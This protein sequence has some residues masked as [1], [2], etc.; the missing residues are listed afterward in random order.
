MALVRIVEFTDPGCP[1]A[2]SAE[3]FRRRIDWLYGDHIEWRMHMVGLSESPEDYLDKGFTP[4]KM[5]R[6]FADIAREHHMPIATH[7]RPRMAATLPAC[8][9]VVAAREHEGE[10]SARRLLRQLRVRH[11]SGG[12]L[13]DPDTIEAAARD[14]SIDPEKLRGWLTDP[15]V[16]ARLRV[17]MAAARDPL[18]AALVLEHRLAPWED[19]L[20]Y[21][22]PSYE[23]VRSSDGARSAVPGFQPFAAY[24]VVLANLLPDVARLGPPQ[25]VEEVLAWAAEPLATQEVA[26]VCGIP[27]AQA[28]E[29][30]GRVAV[31]THVGFDGLW[32]L[33]RYGRL[34]I[35]PSSE[36]A[37]GA[38]ASASAS[39]PAS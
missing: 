16:D 19:G 20:R 18:P 25:S 35:A 39:S 21:T 37:S 15:E 10:A 4:E 33:P 38:T 6:A 17:D 29:E 32:S 12:L 24:E 23:I 28:R 30:L 27:L 31:E 5:A 13:D 22:C 26:V 2:W 14:A 36:R 11:F 8:R 9:A 1:W 3:P 7:E 34:S